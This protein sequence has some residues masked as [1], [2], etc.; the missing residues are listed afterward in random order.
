[1]KKMADLFNKIKSI[2]KD[3]LNSLFNRIFVR[4]MLLSLIIILVLGFSMIYFFY[5]F[6]FSSTENEIVN[7]TQVF[8]DSLYEAVREDDEEETEKLLSRIAEVNSGQAWLINEEGYLIN[9]YPFLEAEAS[10]VQF[11]NSEPIFAGNIIS[12][13]VEPRYFD[14]PM[15]LIG[16][17]IRQQD[18]TA[19]G[20]LVFTSV[21]GINST[22]AQVRSLMI[23]SSFLAIMLGVIL[24]Y[25]WSKS[26]ASPLKHMSKAVMNLSSGNYGHTI[27]LEDSYTTQEITRLQQSYNNLSKELE[28][29]MN[30]LTRER[31][32]L[33]YILTGMQ[34]GVLVVNR[35][36]EVIVTNNSAADLLGH[37]ISLEEKKLNSLSINEDV[38]KTFE[39]VFE[40]QDS[41]SEEFTLKKSR[42]DIR[43]LI[44]CIPIRVAEE[45]W[46][47]AGL[48]HDV[49]ER[50]RFEKLQQDFV[51]N[52]S[53]ELKAPLSSIK[54]SSEILLDGIV[55]DRDKEKKY[56][57]IILNESDRLSQ[58]VDEILNMAKYEN[59]DFSSESSRVEMNSLL[60]DVGSIFVNS[61]DN[62]KR[63]KVNYLDEETMIQ[64]SKPR[65]KQVLYNLLENA[66]KFSDEEAE[67]EL[68]ADILDDREDCV[69]V[70][71]KD[72]GIGI[73]GEE[74]ENVWERFY[75]VDKARTPG[76]EEGS[77]LGLAI[78]KQIIEQ[79]DGEV[80]VESEPGKGSTFGFKIPVSKR[81]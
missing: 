59:S 4:F 54:G 29:S 47:V 79:H 12:Q 16:I 17:P 8:N 11:L 81:K 64:G 56:L 30:E 20:L 73:P 18:D 67:I 39:K 9:A 51:A 19:A 60:Y 44:R 52:V 75:K 80:F 41:Q 10:Q 70:Y 26:L 48:L 3:R 71:V 58:L 15:L 68:G 1:M 53:H 23:Y 5:E 13:E 77:G 55:E 6:H 78:S 74:Q 76:K 33:K 62:E 21:A 46:G 50:W 72:Q 66:R 37:S 42:K 63:F 40:E 27:D 34:E 35:E 14:R 25:S 32:K 31:N 43:V 69:E 22:I 45:F 36:R 28:N 24:A 61:L 57:N 7:N 65:L 2:Y 49:S 38:I